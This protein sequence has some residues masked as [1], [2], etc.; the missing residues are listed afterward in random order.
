[1]I[2]AQYKRAVQVVPLLVT[3]GIAIGAAGTGVAG[4]TTSMTQ[5]DKFT[6][7]LDN[8]FQKVSETMLTYRNRLIL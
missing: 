7:E 6:Y 1:M 8:G 4:I 2:A 5:Y 3:A